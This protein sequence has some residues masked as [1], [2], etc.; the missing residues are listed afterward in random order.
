MRETILSIEKVVFGGEGLGRLPE[1]KIVF[2]PY[3]IPGEKVKI[4]VVEEHKDYAIAQVEDVI[5]PSPNRVKPPCRYYTLCGGCQ[6]QHLDYETELKIKEEVLRDLFIRQG[7]KEEIPLKSVIN[8]PVEYGYRNKLRLHVESPPLKMGFVKRKTHEVLRI[9]ECLLGDQL[10]NEILSYLYDH[11]LWKK[12]SLYIKRIRIEK[13]LLDETVCLLFWSSIAP[14]K[15]D[16]ETLANDFRIKSI[17]YYLKG[18]RAFGPYPDDA[19]HYGRR[20]LPAIEDLV[21]YIRPGVFTQSHWE[22]NLRIM[23]TIRDIAKESDKILDLHS[24]MGNFLLPLVKSLKDVREFLGVDT[25]IQ[26][27]EDGLYTASINRLNG[28]LELR[29]KSAL[30]TLHDAIKEGKK[31]DLVILDPPRGGCKE[32]IRFLPEVASKK[33]IYLSCDAPTLVRDI[34]FFNKA[35]YSLTELYLFDMFPRTYHWETLALLQR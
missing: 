1:G 2:V 32:L 35:G 28:R 8:S 21:Y 6:F 15:R 33:I 14:E 23:E 10:L 34:L 22:I 25:D 29:R 24:G 16:L 18:A 3:V 19:P 12:L 27:I 31:Y 7:Y 13:S 17:F 20:I 9:E 30:E 4:T 11:P 5:I 26:A